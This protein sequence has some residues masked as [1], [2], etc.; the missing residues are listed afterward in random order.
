LSV[1]IKSTPKINR[2]LQFKEE[3]RLKEL[4]NR[5]RETGFER[6]QVRVVLGLGLG[7]VLI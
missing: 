5:K 6:L 4:E 2:N 1:G 7:L 3:I